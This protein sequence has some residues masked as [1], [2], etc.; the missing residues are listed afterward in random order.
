MKINFKKDF[1]F[2][3]NFKKD[4]YTII[5]ITFNSCKIIIWTFFYEK[6]S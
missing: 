5:K 2:W 1:F 6:K 3:S 4:L